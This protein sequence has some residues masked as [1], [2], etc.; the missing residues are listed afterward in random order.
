MTF[1]TGEIHPNTPH[2]CADLLELLVLLGGQTQLY[3]WHRNDMKALL[4]QAALSHEEVDELG[5]F[6]QGS[7]G[8]DG[9][10]QQWPQDLAKNMGHEAASLTSAEGHAR[11]ERQMEDIMAQFDYRLRAFDGFY[12][13]QFE[14]GHLSMH[15]ELD[16]RQ[17]VYCLLLACS[18][19]RSFAGRGVPQRWAKCFVALCRLALAGLLPEHA[20]VRIFD[21]NSD[22]R[23]QYYSNDLRQ[24]LV[25]LGA[26][27][28][29]IGVNLAECSKVAPQGDAGLDLVGTVD[30]DDGASTAFAVLAQCAAQERNWPRKTLEAHPLK[31]RHFFQMQLD[32]PSV[33]F[34]PVCFRSSSGEWCD[35][36][37]AN[38]I[39]LADRRRIL[40]LLERQ[41]LCGQIVGLDWFIGFEQEFW[42]VPLPP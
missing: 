15:H 27:L 23:Q 13:F 16:A 18:R 36:Q 32:Y 35:N 7:A 14:N 11:L 12:P 39:F 28:R 26:D 2:L 19:L 38:G 25:K 9:A 22:D 34:T 41:A 24:A 40:H 42:H 30:F 17:R 33:M 21:A 1:K 6:A 10:G 3:G 31:Y 8:D 37:S 29:V 4:R 20:T 5:G